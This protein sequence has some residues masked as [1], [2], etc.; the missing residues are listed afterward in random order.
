MEMQFH[1][2][3]W[4]IYKRWQVY[5]RLTEKRETL[6]KP[7]I[8]SWIQIIW[9]PATSPSRSNNNPKQTI[10]MQLG[11]VHLLNQFGPNESAHLKLS[12]WV[13]WSVRDLLWNLLKSWL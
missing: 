8:N 1:I 10:K 5:F 9:A 2:Q 7:H 11:Q 13:Q 6:Q 3:I 12:I 4:S